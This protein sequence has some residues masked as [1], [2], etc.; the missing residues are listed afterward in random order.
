MEYGHGTERSVRCVQ[1]DSC[2]GSVL[3]CPLEKNY[4][5]KYHLVK[6]CCIRRVAKLVYKMGLGMT[7]PVFGVSNKATRN[8]SSCPRFYPHF[9]QSVGRDFKLWNPSP[10]DLS[11]W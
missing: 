5:L 2:S 1:L 11:Y 7:E 4:S 3:F 10:Y 6:L 8:L 9:Y